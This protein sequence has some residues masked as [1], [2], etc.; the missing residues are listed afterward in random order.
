MKKRLQ[1]FSSSTGVSP[2]IW[3]LFAVLPFYFIFQWSSIAQIVTGI[4]LSVFFFVS[5]RFAFISTTWMKYLWTSLLM[6]ISLTMTTFLGYVYFAFFLAYLIGNFKNKVAFVTFYV[7]HLVTSTVAINYNFIIQDELF[8]KQFPF[9]VI[10]WISVILLPFNIYNRKKREQLEAQLAFA[11]KRISD[12]IVQEE[13]QRIARDLHDT[14]G[15]KL[16]LIGLK[17]DLARKIMDKDSAQ[18]RAEL[19]DIQQ[20]A[21]TALNEV[22]KMVSNMRGTRI[23]EEISHIKK[24][25]AAAEI[26]VKITG[27]NSLSN[28]SLFLENILGMCLKEAVTNVVKHSK[29]SNCCI[30][31]HQSSKEIIITIK[32]DGIG[33]ASEDGMEKGNGLI[34]MRERLEFVNGS[35][36]TKSE[37]GMNVI[38]KVPNV[39]KQ[40]E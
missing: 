5:Y 29:A 28:V 31:F 3:S 22:R 27:E 10:I 23:K 32:D 20:T 7:I 2:Y 34:G 6:V 19:K 16:S 11:N 15:Q 25:L 26:N 38:I 9:I 37:Q 14:L 17:S 36:E 1:L 13:R 30:S 21:R 8:L 24:L 12:L 33:M 18:A 40:S 4:V 35:L 39:V